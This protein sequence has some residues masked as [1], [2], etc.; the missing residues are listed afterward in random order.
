MTIDQAREIRD[1]FNRK[2]NEGGYLARGKMSADQAHTVKR[3]TA[4]EASQKGIFVGCSV[5]DVDKALQL[6]KK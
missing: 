1:I 2:A 6:A 3:G 4:L 5:K